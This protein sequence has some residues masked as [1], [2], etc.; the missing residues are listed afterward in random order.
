MRVLSTRALRLRAGLIR[1]GRLPGGGG[2]FSEVVRD[3]GAPGK[4]F[5]AKGGSWSVVEAELYCMC[6]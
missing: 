4:G 6:K 2:P 1:V 5:E 3:S